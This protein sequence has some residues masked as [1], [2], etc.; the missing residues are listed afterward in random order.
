MARQI[1]AIQVML[2]SELEKQKE[3]VKVHV[4]CGDKDDDENNANS[5]YVRMGL[6][7]YLFALC[8]I[9]TVGGVRIL[10][11]AYCSTNA[12]KRTC[13]QAYIHMQIHN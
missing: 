6:S 9:D 7:N 1:P 3:Q 4:G 2:Q 10:T 8:T 13:R 12:P 5:R 11:L